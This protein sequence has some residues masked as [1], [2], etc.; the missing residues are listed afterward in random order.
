MFLNYQTL[1]RQ[2]DDISLYWFAVHLAGEILKTWPKMMSSI[3][4]KYIFN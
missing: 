3:L 4:F 2:T 1:N